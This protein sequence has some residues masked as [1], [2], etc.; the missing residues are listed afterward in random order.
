MSVE[1]NILYKHI[2]SNHSI[3]SNIS[4]WK[5]VVPTANRA[6]VLKL[7]HDSETAGHLGI[8]KTYYPIL[9]LYTWNGLRKD[10]RKYVLFVRQIKVQ[11]YLK[12]AL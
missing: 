10:V 8:S 4:D 9:E 5:I 11:I 3:G 6:D 7:Y 12:P 1:N 2:F